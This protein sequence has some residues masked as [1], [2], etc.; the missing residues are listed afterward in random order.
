M[1]VARTWSLGSIEHAVRKDVHVLL[2]VALRNGLLKTHLI[3]DTLLV[4]RQGQLVH[5]GSRLHGPLGYRWDTL[6]EQLL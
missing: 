4:T 2:R 5:V 1:K 3:L 6:L